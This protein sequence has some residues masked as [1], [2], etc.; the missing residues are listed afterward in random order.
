MKSNIRQRVFCLVLSASV[1]TFLVLVGVALIGIIHRQ[2]IDETELG[3]PINDQPIRS[4][5][6]FIFYTPELRRR[7][8]DAALAEE[9][10]RACNISSYLIPFGRRY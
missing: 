3:R 7:G 5:E 2:G 6:A 4:G 9:I 8:I 1:L 10:N